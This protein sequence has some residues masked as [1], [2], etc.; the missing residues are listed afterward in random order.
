MDLIQR[1]RCS[2]ARA[3]VCWPPRPRSRSSGVC[4]RAGMGADQTGSVHHSRPAPGGGADQM[5]RFI[6]G[7][8]TKHNLMKQSII[9]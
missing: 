3:L 1:L 6:Q 8:V 4:S 9:P 2:C 7:V 5:A